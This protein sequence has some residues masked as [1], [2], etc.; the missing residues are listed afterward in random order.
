MVHIVHLSVDKLVPVLG[1]VVGSVVNTTGLGPSGVAAGGPTVGHPTC[2]AK[3]YP[4]SSSKPNGPSIPHSHLASGMPGVGSS[5]SPAAGE[6]AV[7]T[8]NLSIV[9]SNGSLGSNVSPSGVTSGPTRLP[10]SGGLA[11]KVVH[12]PRSGVTVNGAHGLHVTPVLAKTALVPIA[13]VLM[14]SVLCSPK[15]PETEIGKLIRSPG[16]VGTI[17]GVTLTVTEDLSWAT[18]LPA[19]GLT[20]MGVT[21]GVTNTGSLIF[22]VG[23]PLSPP[24]YDNGVGGATVVTGRPG[25][26][27]AG[28]VTL[29]VTS[30]TR[31]C[32][33]AK[34][35]NHSIDGATLQIK[36][37]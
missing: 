2:R 20:A 19:S 18:G 33:V 4:C 3:N 26:V 8:N 5:T 21:A 10:D 27:P 35:G 15:E 14:T 30:S 12:V 17:E 22:G 24:S 1:P 34:Y 28:V 36:R 32:Y 31:W 11:N 13:I 25:V 9:R 37:K 23:T 29:I 6:F 7:R 16:S